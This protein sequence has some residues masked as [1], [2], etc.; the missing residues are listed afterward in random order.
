MQ[1]TCRVRG[2]V[3]V[4]VLFSWFVTALAGSVRVV[5]YPD[6]SA[7]VQE[8]RPFTFRK[9]RV[10]TVLTD[11]PAKLESESVHLRL[12]KDVKLL[13]F[14]IETPPK[15]A[16]DALGLVPGDSVLVFTRSERV[17]RGRLVILDGGDVVL[18]QADGVVQVPSGAVG[19]I[20]NPSVKRLSARCSVVRLRTE[21][22]R[23]GKGVLTL[24]Y[25][26]SGL[27]WGAVYTATVSRDHKTLQLESKVFLTNHS[28]KNYKQAHLVLA[29]GDIHRARAKVP[30][31]SL[32]RQLLETL[33][34]TRPAEGFT[35]TPLYEYHQYTLGRTIDLPDG[36]DRLAIPF[37]RPVEFKSWDE[38]VYD[39]QSDKEKV[40]ATLVFRNTSRP[41][42]GGVVQVYTADDQGNLA[43]IG[44][45][46]IRHTP[47]DEKIRLLLG[48]AFD[49]VGKRVRVSSKR[50][51]KTVRQETW[52]ITIRNHKTEPVSVTVREYAYGDW[53][54]IRCSESW[55]RVS[56]NSFEIPL[57]VPASGENSVTYTIEYRQ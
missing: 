11:L 33:S 4:A 19:S 16:K 27:S 17:L 34:A 25:L 57:A 31:M 3:F 13:D 53:Q 15:G 9:G 40:R 42:P 51:S 21:S 32:E 12:P 46:G 1:N 23:N 52:R 44:E 47:K 26:T 39:G 20:K 18:Q 49:L 48:Y 50:L 5:I 37:L 54:I 22:A 35:E 2:G 30:P 29:A 7:F 45:S 28:G 36:T 43:L 6:G 38:F 24:G 55:R 41:L 8:K 14:S 56:S 10:E